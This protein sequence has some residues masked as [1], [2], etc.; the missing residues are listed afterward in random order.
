MSNIHFWMLLDL[1]YCVVLLS[2]AIFAFWR[3]I[4]FYSKTT[5]LRIAR[6][7]K[8][9]WLSIM[10][11]LGFNMYYLWSPPICVTL[12]LDIHVYCLRISQNKLSAWHKATP[13]AFATYDSCTEIALYE[14]IDTQIQIYQDIIEYNAKLVENYHSSIMIKPIY[15]TGMDEKRQDR[16]H[17]REKFESNVGT[18]EKTK[19]DTISVFPSI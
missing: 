2:F 9:A 5:W 13:E 11:K 17:W 16:V 6:K 19:R 8:Y 4:Y 7:Q 10:R 14:I 3:A 1:S 15:K 12:C 18:G